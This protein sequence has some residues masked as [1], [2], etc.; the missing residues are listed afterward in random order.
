MRLHSMSVNNLRCF[1]AMNIEFEPQLTVLTGMNGSGKSAV[2]E[3]VSIFL[4][5]IAHVVLRIYPSINYELV[6]NNC[7]DMK[8][9]YN[10]S[11]GSQDILQYKLEFNLRNK[12]VEQT[13]PD[14]PW[15][16]WTSPSS[17][18]IVALYGAKRI[19]D[20]YS[21]E[22]TSQSSLSSAFNKALDAAIDFKSTYTWFIE[23]SSE[24]A[25]EGQYRKDY[26]Y[27]IPA[28]SAVRS[29]VS[30]ALGDYSE[31]FV[32]STP[33]DIFITQNNE[34]KQRYTLNQLSDGYRTMLA[35]VMDLAR[36]MAV[37]SD[38][39]QPDPAQILG[40]DAIVLIDEVELHLHPA[41]Q[42]RV[43]P[44][45]IRIFPN[46]QFIVTTHSPQILSSIDSKNVRIIAENDKIYDAPT[47]IFGAEASR[48]LNQIFGVSSRSPSEAVDELASYEKLVYDDKWN[49]Q[50]ALSLRKKLDKRYGG[51]E[52]KL[53]ELDMYIENREWELQKGGL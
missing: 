6:R 4:R 25:L 29:A 53:I 47:G 15:R 49:E 1:K 52:P 39:N 34:E 26:T 13:D 12:S 32:A 18:P 24:E 8:L 22:A 10:Y 37:A 2:L 14:L 40:H 51:S 11:N 30:M 17:L 41:W 21:R 20:N 46:T 7:K 31:P 27:S 19:L 42:Q 38:A 33:P 5:Q 44:T 36:R 28:L 23:K 3:A 35:L 45:L 9:E 48:I 43:L 16:T 50:E